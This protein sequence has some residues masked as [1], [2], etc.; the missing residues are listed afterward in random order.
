MT[1]GSSKRG[2]IFILNPRCLINTYLVFK[3]LINV[4]VALVL[5]FIVFFG[6]LNEPS[7]HSYLRKGKWLPCTFYQ[8]FV[9]ILANLVI[10]S[11]K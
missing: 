4:T 7:E 6:Y 5:Y 2:F 11:M 9:T 1:P 10:V 3:C 8:V